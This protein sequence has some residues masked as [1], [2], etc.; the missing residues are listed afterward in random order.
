MKVKEKGIKIH[1]FSHVRIRNQDGS[2]AGDSGYQGPNQIVNDGVLG[3]LVKSLGSISGS[4]YISYAALGEGTEPGA[5]DTALQSEVTGSNANGNR[6]AVTAAS[7]GSTRVRF[8]GTFASVDSF[9][10]ATESLA[11]IGLFASS[12]GGTIFA[13]NTYGSS[14]CATNQAVEY[15]YDV[16]FATA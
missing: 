11:N 4:S 15:T 1:G 5:T 2:I 12:T 13:G 16:T 7:S 8:T 10:T 9:V 3:Y 14:T 6:D